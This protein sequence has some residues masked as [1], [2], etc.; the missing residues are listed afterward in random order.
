MPNVFQPS[1]RSAV[2]ALVAT[3]VL[4]A[5]SSACAS[6]S[7]QSPVVAAGER[8]VRVGTTGGTFEARVNEVVRAEDAVVAAAP[9]R[10]WA[11]LPGVFGELGLAYNGINDSGRQLELRAVRARGRLA[12]TRLSQYLSCGN[13]LASGGNNADSYDV[14]LNV[15]SRVLAGPDATTSTLQTHVTATARPVAVSGS[16]VACGSTGQLEDAIAKLATVRAAGG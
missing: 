1:S 11:V 9:A 16:E 7:R 3:A 13:S 15:V 2:A 5:V 8:P 6:S 12:K 10:L 14:S 4:V